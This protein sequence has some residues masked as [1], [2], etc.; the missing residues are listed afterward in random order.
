MTLENCFRDF[1]YI[2]NC[3]IY[4]DG[5]NVAYTNQLHNKK[6]LLCN[7]INL[8]SYLIESI[9][10]HKEK[11]YCI[12]DPSLRY[13]IDKPLEYK[14]LIEEGLIYE[15][16]KIADEMILSFALKHKFCW[17]ISNDRF[18]EYIDQLPS[19]EW[20]EERRVPFMIIGDKLSLSPNVAY[21]K[22]DLLP[23]NDGN[24]HNETI[25]TLEVLERI[26]NNQGKLD[27]F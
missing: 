11:I 8:I 20:L 14:Q 25:T 13:H 19:R 7:L 4:V 23:V 27:L 10:F 21:S 17:I 3:I 9:G 12:C 24:N 2:I 5:S 18:R 6:P 15:A 26:E 22:I 16:P 1:S